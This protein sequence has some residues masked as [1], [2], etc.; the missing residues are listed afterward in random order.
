[1]NEYDSTTGFVMLSIIIVILLAVFVTLKLFGFLQWSW[2]WILSPLWIPFV[3][4]SLLSVAL[5][6]YWSITK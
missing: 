1:M 4:V 6:I 3:I 5:L 2:L